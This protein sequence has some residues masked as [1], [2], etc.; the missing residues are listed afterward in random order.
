MPTRY[1][2]D[3]LRAII[4]T[5]LQLI[6]QWSPEA[7]ELVL[8]TAAHES[9]LGEFD[10]QIGGGP[11]LGAWQMEPATEDSIWRDYLEYRGGLKRAVT[12]AT[13][14][15]APDLNR[16]QYD[17]IYGAIMCRVRYLPAPETLPAEHDIEGQA[18]YW[19]KYYNTAQGRG[20]CE[21]Y[22]RDYYRLIMGSD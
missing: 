4:R 20:R 5:A 18:A 19:K 8:G 13:G 17:P 10:R 14:V 3:A 11:A 16:L 7:E 15:V 2:V 21:E 6:D 1:G 9:H 22:V 12:A